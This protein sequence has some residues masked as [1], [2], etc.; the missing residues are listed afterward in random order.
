MLSIIVPSYNEEKNILVITDKVSAILNQNNIEHEIIFVDDGSQDGTFLAINKA[1]EQHS[2]IRG[3]KF[4]RNF[5]KESAIIAGLSEARGDCCVVIDCDLQH[6]PECLPKMYELWQKGFLIVEGVKT[7]RGSENWFY[8]KFTR[9]FYKI[10]GRFIGI[11]LSHASDYKLLD[12][13]IV[14]ILLKLPEKTMF[15]RGLSVC[16]GFSK[17]YVEFEVAPRLEGETKWTLSGLFHYAI[18]NI[19]SFSAF[20][21]QITTF[22]GT[23]MLLL[24]M[25]M[26]GQTLYN[27]LTG[28]AVE[29]FTTVILLL[30]FIGSTLSISLGIIGHYIAR[31]YEEIKG[32]PMYVIDKSIG[33]EVDDESNKMV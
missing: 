7:S 8:A 21:L 4:S 28:N 18:N 31:I 10:I 27:Y 24:F 22:L 2:N 3:I 19:T 5:G 33:A 30:L 16:F 20:P 12:R 6:P 29:G 14:D 17:T 26:G 25:I 1:I 23:L 11:D 15:F 32:R 9:I 13:K